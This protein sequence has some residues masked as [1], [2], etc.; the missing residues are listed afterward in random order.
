RTTSKGGFIEA[1]Y[2]KVAGSSE[3][4]SYTF[5]VSAATN[6]TAGIDDFSG[7]NT[8]SPV[9]TWASAN[10][11]GTSATCS[12]TTAAANE[13]VICAP[14]ALANVSI[15]PP[16]GMTERWELGGTGVT[17][18]AADYLQASAGATGT[19]SAT[20]SASSAWIAIVVALQVGS[21][22]LGASVTSNPTFGLT[23]NGLDQTPTYAL[24][25]EVTDTRTTSLGWNL[26][27]TSTQFT[28]GSATLPTSASTITGVSSACNT[29][30]T[31]TTPTN[32]VTFPVSVP[33][34]FGPPTAVKF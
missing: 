1:L 17:G 29:G 13:A 18:E 3:P 21:G 33:A 8:T 6:L 9:D 11:N 19:K 23:L 26:T 30:S 14:A 10:S 27:I 4:S 5:S 24:P 32:S 28:A 20:L 7:V 15:T 12:L 22:T 2:Y 16:T 34:G 31:C 25:V